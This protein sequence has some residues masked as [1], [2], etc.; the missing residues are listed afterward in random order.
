MNARGSILLHLKGKE[1]QGDLAV[2]RRVVGQ[3]YLSHT[4]LP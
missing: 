1:F 3:E 4:S 2:K